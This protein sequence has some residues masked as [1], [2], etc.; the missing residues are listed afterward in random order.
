MQKQV[1]AAAG[2]TTLGTAAK[3][4]GTAILARSAPVAPPPAATPLTNSSM[5][6]PA[7]T[8]QQNRTALS[9]WV[10]GD[11]YSDAEA[12][13]VT[14]PPE[15]VAGDL[16]MVGFGIFRLGDH[17][18][19]RPSDMVLTL[20]DKE[21]PNQ[22]PLAAVMEEKKV[23]RIFDS[24]GRPDTI[25]DENDELFVIRMKH[26]RYPTARTPSPTASRARPSTPKRPE[27]FRTT[28]IL[29][30]PFDKSGVFLTELESKSRAVSAAAQ[31]RTAT[32][33]PKP[34]SGN[35]GVAS[36]PSSK[37][38]VAKLE[39]SKEPPKLEDCVFLPMWGD[40]LC[41][42]CGCRREAHKHFKESAEEKR[43][44]LLVAFRQKMASSPVQHARRSILESPKRRVPLPSH[45]HTKCQNFRA[46]W[47]RPHICDNCHQPL[48]GHD[49]IDPESVKPKPIQ[50]A[51]SPP[52]SARPIRGIC[53]EYIPLWNNNEVCGNCYHEL[54]L[55]SLAALPPR[56]QKSRKGP[57]T[58]KVVDPKTTAMLRVCA[59]PWYSI[60]PF[61]TV[62]ELARIGRSC[63]LLAMNARTLLEATMKQVADFES[64]EERDALWRQTVHVAENLAPYSA[65]ARDMLVVCLTLTNVDPESADIEEKINSFQFRIDLVKQVAAI[66]PLSLSDE[67]LT[68]FAELEQNGIP[69]NHDLYPLM[70]YFRSLWLQYRVRS[71]AIRYLSHPKVF[72]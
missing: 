39:P 38:T 2:P 31:I 57:S 55:H 65:V 71:K 12:F 36:P 29:G 11:R 26:S 5:P 17:G 13:R 28:A 37:Q 30:T 62:P 3:D 35:G 42:N 56:L 44:K 40:P 48:L 61:C 1:G 7:G 27:A 34:S 63:R 8:L 9:C 41:G 19:V 58:Q 51:R 72:L 50:V 70:A 23:R 20:R 22:T 46:G 18:G 69:E 15:A 24:L 54:E 52:P 14:L 64:H 45:A 43:E 67:A 6:K 59:L 66:H 53:S 16:L 60:L 33:S 4:N 32:G 10:K 49:N 47:G 68:L 21:I 25:R